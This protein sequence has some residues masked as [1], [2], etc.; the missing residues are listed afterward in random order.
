MEQIKAK[1]KKWGNSFGIILPKEILNKEQLEEGEEITLTISP[2]KITT[3]SDLMKL[4][5]TINIPKKLKKSTKQI[6]KETDE[7]FYSE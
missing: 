6:M 3:V 1:V 5:L 4:G 7:A 2:K